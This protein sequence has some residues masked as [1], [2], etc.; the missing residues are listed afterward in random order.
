M[1][2]HYAP[3]TGESTTGLRKQRFALFSGWEASDN[4]GASR[5]PH[6]TFPIRPAARPAAQYAPR[7]ITFPTRAPAPPPDCTAP[8]ISAFPIAFRPFFSCAFRRPHMPLETT[9]PPR[10]LSGRG[11]I[12]HGPVG[13]LYAPVSFSSISTSTTS[14]GA[15]TVA[16]HVSPCH[17]IARALFR[18]S[19]AFEAWTHTRPVCTACRRTATLYLPCIILP[20]LS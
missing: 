4:K 18:A 13:G 16:R 19:A 12:A 15:P 11:G 5:F 10:L 6:A 7:N 14:G 9:K 20:S 17:A 3:P 1:R 8:P 2:P